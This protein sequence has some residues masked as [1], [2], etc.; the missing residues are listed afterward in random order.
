MPLTRR[1]LLLAAAVLPL[2]RPGTAQPAPAIHVVKD[3]N[4][5]CCTAWVEHL[6]ANGFA[7]TVEEMHAGLLVAF[8][9]ERGVPLD[10][11]SCHTAEVGGY[12]IEGHV[13]AGDIV[14]LLS[15]RPEALGLAVPGMPYGSPGMGPEVE[16][17]AYE[18][19]LFQADGATVAWASY[20]AA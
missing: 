4:C 15:E 3:P 14:H 1:T 7:V 6:Q 9:A 19:V 16:R 2:A 17:E 12:I 20:E 13:P 8:K 5:E 18:V 11:Q 10:L